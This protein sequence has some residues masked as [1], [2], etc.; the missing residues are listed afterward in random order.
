VDIILSSTGGDRVTVAPFET[1]RP[2]TPEFG[3][4]YDVAAP[5]QET[6]DKKYLSVYFTNEGSVSTNKGQLSGNFSVN[7]E[8]RGTTVGTFN[9]LFLC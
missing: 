4:V 9:L 5:L 7:I 3:G 8:L 2:P 6:P 1:Y